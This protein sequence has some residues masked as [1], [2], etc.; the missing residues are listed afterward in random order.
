MPAAIDGLTALGPLH[1]PHSVRLIRAIQRLRPDLPQ[2][3]SFDT[4]FH[5][6]QSNLVRRFAPPRAQFDAG[7]KRYG[8]HGPSCKS[9]AAMLARQTPD[10]ARGRVVVAHLGGGASLCVL[11]AGVSRD[12]SMGFSALDGVPMATRCGALDAGVVLHLIRQCGLSP[13]AVEDMLYRRSG[14]LGVSGISADSRALLT[15]SAP[16][17]REALDLFTFRVAGEVTRLATTLGGLDGIVFTAGIGGNQPAIREA[18]CRRLGW[19]GVVIDPAAN[20]T[21]AGCIG[22]AASRVAV[23]VVRTDEEQVIA[24]EELAI[25]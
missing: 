20:A 15:S 25:L 23:L 3:A 17:A 6:T 11:E 14:L 19:L 16:E 12:T 18:I 7:V 1:Q 8:F 13:D 24:D 10:V 9:I 4:A 22:A 21:N 2:V 5:R